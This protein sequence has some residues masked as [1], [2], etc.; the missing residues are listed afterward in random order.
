M[1]ELVR[2]IVRALADSPEEIDI[3]EIEGS[4]TRIL[5]IKVSEQDVGKLLGRKGRNINA[6][7]NIVSA[8]G[9]RKRHYIINVVA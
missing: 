5:E 7:R 3:G 2:T 4:N 8:A 6:L 1:K 9:K